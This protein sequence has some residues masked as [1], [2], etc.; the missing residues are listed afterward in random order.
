MMYRSTSVIILMLFKT[1]ILFLLESYRGVTTIVSV[2]DENTE[3]ISE[4]S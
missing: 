2:S 3:V 4:L 1:L